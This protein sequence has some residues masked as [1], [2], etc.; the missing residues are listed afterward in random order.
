MARYQ[1]RQ[2]FSS[3][4][5]SDY[6]LVFGAEVVTEAVGYLDIRSKLADSVTTLN[7][8]C[9]LG[10]CFAKNRVADSV[11]ADRAV[12]GVGSGI[13]FTCNSISIRWPSSRK[14]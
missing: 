8:H 3:V 1:P 4:P 9:L 11:I 10:R 2:R 14:P 13:G 5:K 6:W 12:T 7:A